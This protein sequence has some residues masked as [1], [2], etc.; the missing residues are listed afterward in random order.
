M[1]VD[2]TYVC[3]CMCVFVRSNMLHIMYNSL[4]PFFKQE[5]LDFEY[6]VLAMSAE[7][8]NNQANLGLQM[9]NQ[10]VIIMETYVCPT[11]TN[12]YAVNSGDELADN[13]RLLSLQSNKNTQ[14]KSR[15]IVSQLDLHLNEELEN[16][17][18]LLGHASINKYDNQHVDCICVNDVQPPTRVQIREIQLETDACINND[19]ERETSHSLHNASR[20]ASENAES[21]END[22]KKSSNCRSRGP[23]GVKTEYAN[24]TLNVK[25][26]VQN[27]HNVCSIN[28]AD[29]NV[30]YD[31]VVKSGKRQDDYGH[32]Y[33]TKYLKNNRRAEEQSDD[34][35]HENA[36]FNG[37]S[38]DSNEKFDDLNLSNPNYSSQTSTASQCTTAPLSVPQSISVPHTS[39]TSQCTNFFQSQNFLGDSFCVLTNNAELALPYNPQSQ[40]MP[41]SNDYQQ[42]TLNNF[43]RELHYERTNKGNTCAQFLANDG[44]EFSQILPPLTNLHGSAGNDFPKI[45][46]ANKLQYTDVTTENA[47][48]AAIDLNYTTANPLI[49]DFRSN[50]PTKFT[51]INQ[52]AVPDTNLNSTHSGI[53]D[54]GQ[55]MINPYHA[56]YVINQTPNLDYAAPLPEF[57]YTMPLHESFVESLSPDT[58]RTVFPVSG[59]IIDP[60]FGNKADSLFGNT[61]GSNFVNTV[62]PGFGNTVSPKS[63]YVPVTDFSSVSNNFNLP[64]ASTSPSATSSTNSLTELELQVKNSNTSVN[65]NVRSPD[66]GIGDPLSPCDISSPST[67]AQSP[68]SQD[69]DDVQDCENSFLPNFD[70]LLAGNK[71]SSNSSNS[72]NT[73]PGRKKSGSQKV[74]ESSYCK[75]PTSKPTFA[76]SLTI[77][78][79]I[80]VPSSTI[81][82]VSKQTQQSI[83]SSETKARPIV[84]FSATK[85][86]PIAPKPQPPPG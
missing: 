77:P 22:E 25:V 7:V 45:Y 54:I 31:S 81:V 20:N 78:C 5:V 37:I 70:L 80:Q 46:C 36:T 79:S 18:T 8:V 56:G 82:F 60:G 76:T 24:S 83:P 23:P 48:G 40:Y 4:F 30:H 51:A 84:P 64:W 59:S 73:K 26:N 16:S 15:D 38:F 62:G 66:S 75:E 42:Q 49:T 63:G 52:Q 32:F 9:K 27:P 67:L 12:N 55:I 39:T 14:A 43:W 21:N 71:E 2:I 44:K 10:G 86:R 57:P 69:S 6:L 29:K 85:V 61:A 47:Q 74:K 1:C 34:H 28:I 33:A 72:N 65:E 17:S 11:N 19:E 50:P 3:E 41:V 68:A 58:G 35:P 13:F 53:N